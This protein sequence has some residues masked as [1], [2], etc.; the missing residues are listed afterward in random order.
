MQAKQTVPVVT[1]RNDYEL[2]S[3]RQCFRAR[4]NRIMRKELLL[5]DKHCHNRRTPL[6]TTML[7]TVRTL[8]SQTPA[9]APQQR[10]DV[11]VDPAA[12]V[13]PRTSALDRVRSQGRPYR[14][15]VPG[16]THEQYMTHGAYLQGRGR[17]INDASFAFAMEPQSITPEACIYYRQNHSGLGARESVPPPTTDAHVHYT[18][19]DGTQHTLVFP[20][21]QPV[22]YAQ[23]AQWIRNVFYGRTQW[24]EASNQSPLNLGYHLSSG[25]VELQFAPTAQPWS[26]TLDPALAQW[27]GFS[28]RTL[29]AVA[30]STTTQVVLADEARRVLGPYVHLAMQRFS[31]ARFGT[32]YAERSQQSV[33]A[34]RR[35]RVT[36]LANS[37]TEQD[38]H[39]LPLH[40]A[41][42]RYAALSCQGMSRDCWLQRQATN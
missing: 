13:D 33:V 36:R 5:D 12:S 28:T 29:F 23:L 15:V 26:L 27:L 39:N 6:S 4:P 35:W 32:N 30:A 40:P 18:W 37:T 9:D 10:L 22:D 41:L 8:P 1:R 38:S 31:N 25:R 42:M 3:D 24:Q 21:D 17:R 16:S 20:Q 19:T 11:L 7:P 14:P 34:M 2:T